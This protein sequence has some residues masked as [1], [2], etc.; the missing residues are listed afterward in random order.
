MFSESIESEG[1]LSRSDINGYMKTYGTNVENAGY[2]YLDKYTSAVESLAAIKDSDTTIQD[3]ELKVEKLTIELEQLNISLQKA[4][5]ELQVAK[6]QQVLDSAELDKKIQDAAV[7]LEKAKEGNAQEQ[8]IDT[9]RNEIDNIQFQITTLLKKYDEYKII[10]NFDGV[11]TKLDMQV[12]DSIETNN[13][14]SSDQKYIY[15]E[16]PDLLE[17]ELS[18]DQVDIV[19][20]NV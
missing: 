4:N 2:S 17:V 5:N 7:D 8:E 15:V 9:I 1:S 16:T 20:I 3:A 14:S 13:S 19:K 10:A 18:I 12:G 6:T 11:V